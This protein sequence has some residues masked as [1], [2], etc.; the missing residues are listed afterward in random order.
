MDEI[1]HEPDLKPLSVPHSKRTSARPKSAGLFTRIRNR[2]DK[3]ASG[4]P[5]LD[6]VPFLAAAAIIGIAAITA[7]V[8]TPSYVVSVNGTDIGTVRK[9]AVFENVI[10]RVEIRASNILGYEYELT[11]EINYD[12]ALTR[13]GELS[14]VADF[15]SHLF[16]TIDEIFLGYSLNVG[17]TRMGA[18]VD[19]AQ[20]D[21]VLEEIKA[22]Y[23]N[24]N[25]VD[26][27]FVEPLQITHEYLPATAEQDMDAIHAALT[28][29]RNGQ[30]V[31]EVKQGDTFMA[32]ALR[33]N[34][35]M[36][37]LEGLNP[38][39]NINRLHIGQ[40]LTVKEEIPFLSVR[41]YEDL[42]YE[43]AVPCPI[44][45]VPDNS[46]YEGESRVIDAGIPGTALVH[47][48]ITY[49]NGK[50]EETH[51]VSSETMVE[52]T[53]KYVAV[54]TKPRPSWY[55]TGSFIWPTSGRISSYFGY[56][57]IFGS[58]SYHGGI[59]IAAAYGTAVKAADG[60]TVIFAGTAS[61]SNWTYGKLV[62]ID[63]GNGKH[64]YYGHNSSIV[65]K[66]GDKVYQGQTIAKVGST[67][68]STGNHCHFEVRINGTRVNPLSYLP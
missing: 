44:E 64:S 34:M 5:L 53:I 6:P 2:V 55:P 33:N 15:E 60:G 38:G 42:I 25:T 48:H 3:I 66:K 24:E 68:R 19:R 30:T 50:E 7:V 65:V 39:V 54:G 36:K 62:I 58:T 31:Y 63:H 51:V 47:A 40:L 22:P 23:V 57:K 11:S 16:D 49:V 1:L 56:R 28:E 14:P 13:R 20:L 37:E 45:E 67:G 35:T 46:M 26:S 10:N 43:E 21:A 61:G 4:H 41:T 17:G 29:N 52:P 12:F 59:D 9:P 27:E 18:A 8:Y 32:I